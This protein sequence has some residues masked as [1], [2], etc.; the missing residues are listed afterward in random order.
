MTV[1]G[2]KARDILADLALDIDL[3]PA[4]FPHMTLR[5]TRFAKTPLRIARVSFTGDLSFD[6]SIRHSAAAALWQALVQAAERHGAAPIG[7]EALSILRAEKG[8]IMIGKDTDGETMPH[9]LGFG[10]PR[11]KKTTAFIGDR[12]LHTAKANGARRKQLVGLAVEPGEKALPTAAHLIEGT[13]P[14]S[15]GYVT[16]S[17]DSPTLKRPI[18][19]GLIE[20]GADRW[21]ETISVWHMGETRKATICAPCVFDPEGERLHA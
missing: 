16:S 10:V 9:D 3:S 2:P 1:A 7:L 21:G 17:Y 20:T 18:A 11:Q 14:Q 19:L 12:S 15:V 5:A 6:L 13:P 8:Y 4:A